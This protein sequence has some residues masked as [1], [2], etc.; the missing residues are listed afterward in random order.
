[1][2]P[3]LDDFLFEHFKDSYEFQK[4]RTEKVRDK[5]SFSI[6]LLTVLWGGIVY[7]VASYPLESWKELNLCFLLPLGGAVVGALWAS[8]KIFCVF[9]PNHQFET[10]LG[11]KRLQ[12]HANYLVSYLQVAG[13][14]QNS[15]RELRKELAERYM[16][17]ADQSALVTDLR[18]LQ[19]IQATRRALFAFVLLAFSLPGFLYEKAR[20]QPE[21]TKVQLIESKKI[22]MSNTPPPDNQQSSTPTPAPAPT[23]PPR[24]PLPANTMVSEGSQRDLNGRQ[25]LNEDNKK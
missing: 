22:P 13:E 12:D 4:E 7:V 18:V 17:A 8:W 5:G 2:P 14:E 20:D 1:M 25:V 24:I 10:I 23:R 11:C 9:A 21:P 15:L 16:T 19:V 3:D 6:N